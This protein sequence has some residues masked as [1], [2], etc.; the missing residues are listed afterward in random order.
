MGQA[1]QNRTKP[2]EI[3]KELQK[4]RSRLQAMRENILLGKT[5][6]FL[7]ENSEVTEVDPSAQQ[8]AAS[9]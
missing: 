6:D 3:V 5:M 9:S 1:I 2:E 7:V 4:D 8:P